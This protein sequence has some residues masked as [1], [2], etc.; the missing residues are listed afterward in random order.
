MYNQ[1]KNK[2]W[3]SMIIFF[4]FILLIQI[5]QAHASDEDRVLSPYPSYGTYVAAPVSYIP[6]I[7][8][9]VEYY[10]ANGSF[11]RRFGDAYLAAP[12]PVGAIVRTIPPNYNPIVIDGAIYYIIHGSVYLQTLNGYQVMPQKPF[13]IERYASEQNNVVNIPPQTA[14]SNQQHAPANAEESFTVNIPNSKG[15]YTPVTIKK[16]GDGFIGPQGE[17]YQEFPK[18][19]ELKIKYAKQDEALK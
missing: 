4:G 18:V 7:V 9:G 15:G 8:S 16:S 5:A 10:Y 6:V 13:M 1:R 2:K 3:A 14:L 17:Y 19:E 11:Y 12:A